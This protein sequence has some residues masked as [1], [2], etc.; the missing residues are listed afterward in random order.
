MCDMSAF[1]EVADTGR[2]RVRLD[3][4]LVMKQGV[5]GTG[6]FFGWWRKEN[7]TKA[8]LGEKDFVHDK[9]D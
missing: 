9:F 3:F 8:G 2:W 5:N 4:V 6:I 7:H 1:V